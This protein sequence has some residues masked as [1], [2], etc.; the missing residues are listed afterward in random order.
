MNH[1]HAGLDALRTDAASAESLEAHD[2]TEKETKKP[3]HQEAHDEHALTNHTLASKEQL[4]RPANWDSMSRTAKKQWK[5]KQA[6]HKNSCTSET[7]DPRPYGQGRRFLFHSNLARMMLTL[8]RDLHHA[9]ADT[10]MSKRHLRRYRRF[11]F[12]VLP[13]PKIKGAGWGG[14]AQQR[15]PGETR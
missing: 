3:R 7:R 6:K 9:N 15:A 11:Y 4:T 5:T 13:S 8:H 14:G 1:K 10:N 12:W 2:A